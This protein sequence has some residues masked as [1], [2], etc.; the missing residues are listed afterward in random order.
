AHK[1]LLALVRGQR[2]IDLVGI[3]NRIDGGL[4]NEIDEAEL[5]IYFAQVLQALAQLVGR[6]NI[7]LLHA[8][9]IQHP[10]SIFE[11]LDAHEARIAQMVKAALLNGNRKVRGDSGGV[12]FDQRK[13]PAAPA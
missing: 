4:R 3:G 10:G 2:D 8:E 7:A 5:A 6:E 1:E 12:H 13:T 11:E 9:K